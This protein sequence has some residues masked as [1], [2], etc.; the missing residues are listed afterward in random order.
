MVLPGVFD[1]PRIIGLISSGRYPV[2]KVVT[3]VIG[4]RDIVAGGFGR[5]LDPAGDAQKLLVRVDS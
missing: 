1:W 2:E 5:L 4:V 3:E